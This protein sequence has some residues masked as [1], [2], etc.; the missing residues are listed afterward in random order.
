M[1]VMTILGT[2]PEIIRLSCV[3]PELDRFC[4]HTLVHTGQNYD[5]RLND[6][7]FNELELRKPDIN[8]GIQSITPGEQIGKII[9]DIE[10]VLVTIKPDKVLILGDTNSGLVAII[11]KRMGITVCHMEAGNRCFD[12]NV[13]EEVNRRIIDHCSDVHMPYT[14]RSRSNLLREG[15]ASDKIFVTGNP[16]NEV[17]N[18]YADKID[19]SNILDTMGLKTK[20][21][22][23]VE[24]HRAE[25]VDH[26]DR[27]M[28]ILECLSY[29]SN[30]YY[31]PIIYSV[32]PHTKDRIASFNI[33]PYTGIRMCEPFGLFDF[34]ALELNAKCVLT[35]SGTVPEECTIL[36][37]PCVTV[38]DVT[39]RPE[40]IECGSNILAGVLP[41]GIESAIDVAL[42]GEPSCWVPP[43]GYTDKDVSSKVIK[44]I[45]GYGAIVNHQPH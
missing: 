16:I 22:F 45:L 35:D 7:F 38:R 34:V 30:K 28:K 6:I 1:K 25:T 3:L 26:R 36:K 12:D 23:L 43:A 33:Q 37:V 39:E 40:T 21:Y 20:G 29:L 14:E 2:R 9:S 42:S 24:V 27:L 41:K 10:G 8:L 5:T 11:A 17:L 4:Q 19:N 44:I 31:I 15:I 18:K 32:H 13:P